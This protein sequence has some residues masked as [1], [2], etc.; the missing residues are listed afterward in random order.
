MVLLE[1]ARRQGDGPAR[2]GAGPILVKLPAPPEELKA[3]TERLEA[4]SSQELWWRCIDCV[5]PEMR[6]AVSAAGT[7]RDVNRFAQTAAAMPQE[8]RKMY[9]AVLE[10][11]RCHDLSAA[12]N[13]AD[14]LGSYILREDINSPSGFAK[15]KIR[16]IMDE[17]MGKQVL[18]NMNL[19]RCGEALMESEH[20]IQTGYGLLQRRDGQ[21]LHIQDKHTGM[22]E[23]RRR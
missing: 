14:T 1:V 4:A 12:I 11:L 20:C 6:D 16:S 15:E 18:A 13:Q 9:K 3:V 5:I 22:M 23:M 7:I 8:R 10:G 17:T 19:Y 21:E 2:G